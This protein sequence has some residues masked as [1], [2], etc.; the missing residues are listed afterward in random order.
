MYKMVNIFGAIIRFF[1]PNPF[2]NIIGDKNVANIFNIII[3]GF[4]LYKLSYWLTGFGYTKRVD[5][6]SVGSIGY[7]LSYIYLTAI[8]TLLGIFIKD[9]QIMLII[10]GLVYVIS[11][12]LTKKVFRKRYDF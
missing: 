1:L 8:I 9:I 2:I 11:A 7:L 10:F 5:D 3:G 4:I 6:P 12:I